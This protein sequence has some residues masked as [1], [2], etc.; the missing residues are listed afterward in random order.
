[1]E[2]LRILHLAASTFEADVEQ[3]L[4]ALQADG[5]PVTAEAVKKKTAQ[6]ADGGPP[7]PEL[8]APAIDLAAYDA[9]LVEVAS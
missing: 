6:A 4:L 7:V 1:V 9:L 3:A 2:Y 5:T 8:E